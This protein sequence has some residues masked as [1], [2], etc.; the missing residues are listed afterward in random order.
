MGRLQL[1]APGCAP[2]F[3]FHNAGRSI[4]SLFIN[5]GRANHFKGRDLHARRVEPAT[6]SYS[7][8]AQWERDFSLSEGKQYPLQYYIFTQQMH[9]CSYQFSKCSKTLSGTFQ[10][11]H[12][13]NNTILL[14]GAVLYCWPLNCF[15]A[16]PLFIFV[17]FL[18]VGQ[19]RSDCVTVTDLFSSQF[20]LVI[21]EPT[22]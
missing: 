9:V 14:A 10:L 8:G 6:E 18:F 12:S 16:S 4:S 11:F 17:Y 7:S 2:S 15:R 19:D 22:F 1:N 5:A 20:S 3:C 21:V 13:L